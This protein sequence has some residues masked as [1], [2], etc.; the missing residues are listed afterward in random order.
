M[1][2]VLANVVWPALFLSIRLSAW[3]C[4]GASLLI[5][6]AALWRGARMRPTVALGASV[7]M[8]TVSAFCGAPLL[9]L[10]GIHWETL[11]N[12]TYNAWLGWG[13]FN[14]ATQVATWFIAVVLNTF[15]ET[16]VL[17]LVFC[18]PWTRR[19]YVVVLLANGV[20]V[21]LAWGS[22]LIFAPQ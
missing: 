10:I 3:W 5:E 20:T 22:T 6:A 21:A 2:L 11:A 18:M 1:F 15:I 4:I 8:N 14:L 16:F 13:T 19:L 9:P 7:V 17:W 12:L